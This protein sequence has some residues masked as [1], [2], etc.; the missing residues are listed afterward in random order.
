MSGVAIVTWPINDVGGINSWCKNF[1]TG[2]DTLGVQNTTYYATPQT[3]FACDPLKEQVKKRCSIL[4]AKHLSYRPE[5]MK[6]TIARL[7]AYDLIV[8]LHPSPHP[9]KAVLSSK[10][11]KGWMDLYRGTK[12]PKLVIF[13]D[14]NWV[15]TNPWFVEVQEHI[16]AI[17]AAQ[18]LFLRSVELYP[19]E[20]P[21]K[22]EYFPL[23]MTMA[24]AMRKQ[25]GA[26]KKD[27]AVVCTQ[28]L[29][30]K[31]HH[32]LLPVLPQVKYP[33]HFYGS[34]MEYCNLKAKGPFKQVMRQ[35]LSTGEM[36]NRASRHLF[37]GFVPYEKVMQAMTCA[38]VSVDLSTKGYT[39]MTHWEPLMLDTVSMIEQAVVDHPA[40]EIPVDC[41]QPYDLG[42][43]ATAINSA[44]SSRVRTA[45]I[46]ANARKFIKRCDCVA[47][48]KRTLDWL[49]ENGVCRVGA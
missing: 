44:I 22:W 16:H 2:L 18:K 13:H 25:Y 10:Y 38:R 27:V 19:T 37:H 5:H 3:R 41:C 30:W 17:I 33:V 24:A 31:N 39:N 1:V 42:D 28:W 7:N 23:D 47:V 29:K 36:F 46:T 43:V 11:A 4:R 45:A 21:K 48:A 15:K 8:F 40:C 20:C 14:A 12:V 26:E 34:G 6:S 32:K 35:D 9:T 49:A